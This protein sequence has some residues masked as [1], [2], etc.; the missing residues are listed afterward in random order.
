VPPLFG[1]QLVEII[2]DLPQELHQPVAGAGA[3]GRQVP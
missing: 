1:A 3:H 2:G